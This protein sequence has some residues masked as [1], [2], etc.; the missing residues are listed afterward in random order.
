M[1]EGKEYVEESLNGAFLL[2]RLFV[3]DC[4]GDEDDDEP[5]FLS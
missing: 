4:E 5:G 2:E 3:E 1:F